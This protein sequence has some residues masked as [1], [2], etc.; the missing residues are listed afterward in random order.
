MRFPSAPRA[1]RSALPVVVLVA[2]GTFGAVA[3]IFGPEETIIW[4]CLNPETGKL[5]SSIYDENHIVNGEV[6][7]CHCYDPCGPEKTCPIVVDAGEPGPGC[8]AGDGG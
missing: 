1:L 7:P 8:D 4:T 3:C 5:D 2:F 6:D